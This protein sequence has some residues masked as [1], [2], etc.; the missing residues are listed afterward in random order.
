MEKV[1]ENGSDKIWDAMQVHNSVAVLLF[2]KSKDSFVF[3]KQFR[4]AIYLNNSE[5]EQKNNKVTINSEKFPGVLGITY[6]LCAGLI[7]K[8]ASPKEIAK[9]E[10]L[11]ECGF[12]VPLES[13]EHV[14]SYRAGVGTTGAK[15]FLFYAEVTEEM[16][17]GKGGGVVEEGEMID[18]IEIHKSEAMTFVM[19]ESIN[20]PIGMLFAV[21][22]YFQNK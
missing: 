21:L 13:I 7:D 3:V 5:T 8:D 6:E 22:W 14:T 19:D 20:K 12:D 9:L 16:R 17:T 4:P 1:T 18:V 10:I 2:N 15:Q 11:E